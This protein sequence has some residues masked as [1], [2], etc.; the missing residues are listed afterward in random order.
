MNNIIDK[1]LLAGNKFMPEIHLRQPQFT[2]SAC[3]LFTNYKQRIQKFKETGDTN[4]IY[5]NELDKACFAHDGAYSDSKDLTK[6]TVADKILENKAF[7][8]AKD[9]KYDGYQRGLASMVYKFFDKKSEG[10]GVNTKLAPQ[11]QQLAEKLHKSIIR[12]FEKRKVYA[13]FKD[14]IWGAD[15]A[16]MQ[17]LSR[18]NKGIRFLLFVI[19]IF[20]KYAWVVPL[21]DKK[22][23]SIV[24]TFQSILKESNRKPNKIWVDKDFEFYNASFKKWLQDNDI[25]MYS[26]HNERKPV[27]A[28]RCIRT[29][30]S[31]IYKHITSLSKNVY[32]DR[33]DDIVD[34]YNN[35]YHTTIKMK[36][37]NVKDNTY[38]NTD[39][40]INNKDPKFKVDDHVRIS[41]YKNIFAKGFTPD[42][43]EEVFVIK[44]F[45]NAVP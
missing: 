34:E 8:I 33:L 7:N 6:R 45:K 24:T 21:K 9:P 37:I 5:Q 10:R 15:L 28:E 17:L 39:K 4:Y 35:A 36:P 27:V 42:W 20:S 32:I 14:N 38:I 25:V 11:N 13:A 2:Y 12:K 3:G 40:K 31:K 44:K 29:L 23:V 18:Y 1:F 41:K 26:T 16:D 19:D 43:F 22:G 30:K